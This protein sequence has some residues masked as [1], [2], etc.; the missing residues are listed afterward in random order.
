[1]IV[2]RHSSFVICHLSYYPSKIPDF[3]GVVG[4]LRTSLTRHRAVERERGC[5]HPQL[6]WVHKVAVDIVSSNSFIATEKLEVA[7]MTRK[8]KKGKRKK[9]KAGLNKSILDVGMGML[10]QAIEDKVLEACGVFI[11]VPTKSVKPSQTC[12]GCGHQHKKTLDERVHQCKVCGFTMARDLAAA[13]VMLLW[14]QDK[15]PGFGTSLADADAPRST[16]KTRERKQ[17]ASMKQLGQMKRQKSATEPTGQD[18]ETRPS[19]K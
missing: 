7:Q 10:R 17:A 19:T 2:I 5:P 4:D 13:L 11:E 16:S 8:A 6:D 15:L 9:Q 12:P 14:A 18:V 1:M 3:V